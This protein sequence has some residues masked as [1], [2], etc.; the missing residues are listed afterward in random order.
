MNRQ[1]YALTSQNPQ[2]L[3]WRIVGLGVTAAEAERVAIATLPPLRADDLFAQTDHR[4]LRI[5]SRTEA[6][7]R[8]GITDHVVTSYYETDADRFL[9]DHQEA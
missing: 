6:R 9:G 1:Y 3:G 7:R 2:L 5:V 4:N 8:Y